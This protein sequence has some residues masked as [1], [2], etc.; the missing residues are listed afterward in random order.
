MRTLSPNSK[1]STVKALN[2]LMEEVTELSDAMIASP[3]LTETI[4]SD[5]LYHINERS[6]KID[7]LGTLSRQLQ[8]SK[9]G[10]ANLHST[11]KAYPKIAARIEDVMEKLD[12][13]VNK[14]ERTLAI[15]KESDDSMT[16][17]SS[18]AST[19]TNGTRR[20]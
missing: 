15:I 3:I 18:L 2:Q 16:G 6:E 20:F 19:N 13:Q 10:I 8:N 14:I 17:G 5:D 4:E 1:H 7:Q 9:K 11:Y 12:K